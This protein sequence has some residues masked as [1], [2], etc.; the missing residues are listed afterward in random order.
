MNR[1]YTE[2]QIN[3]IM[4]LLWEIC[5]LDLDVQIFI[6]EH[7]ELAHRLNLIIE[8]LEKGKQEGQ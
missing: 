8:I 3:L 1:I 5:E 7:K 6:S 4:K 2:K